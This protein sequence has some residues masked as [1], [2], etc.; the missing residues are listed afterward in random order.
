MPSSIDEVFRKNADNLAAGK[1]LNPNVFTSEMF[2]E[3]ISTHNNPLTDLN[4]ALVRYSGV[5][6][7]VQDQEHIL[8]TLTDSN[9]G[10]A[11]AGLY[12]A[13]Y[14]KFG[15]DAVGVVLDG[16]SGGLGGSAV[17]LTINKGLEITGDVVDTVL[18]D[19]YRTERAT[20]ITVK[21]FTKLDILG[22]AAD[23]LIDLSDNAQMIYVEIPGEVKSAFK[24]KKNNVKRLEKNILN[25][26]VE[27]ERWR[28]VV[29]D[30]SKA[31]GLPNPVPSIWEEPELFKIKL[32]CVPQISTRCVEL[33][34]KP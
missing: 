13:G 17:K 29:R 7:Y 22:E 20:V 25:G 18:A 6:E 31:K 1:Q 15:A 26:K 2:L 30:L 9:I 11:S 19:D 21:H 24:A 8:R 5:T 4:H 33:K 3:E 23:R 34:A 27:M 14:A 12:V 10:W 28:R 16:F 32:E